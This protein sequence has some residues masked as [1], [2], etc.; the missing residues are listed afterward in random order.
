MNERF[1]GIYDRPVE[2]EHAG[3]MDPEVVDLCVAL[4]EV[5]GI[6]TVGSCS[7][8]KRHPMTVSFMARDMDAL[9]FVVDAV[10]VLELPWH[11]EILANPGEFWFILGGTK[12]PVAKVDAE[13]IARS[14]RDRKS[15]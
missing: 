2:Y 11:I 13:A 6:R 5:P 9:G 3:K 14:L 4:N 10:A 1:Q 15:T 8:H 7:G 12:L